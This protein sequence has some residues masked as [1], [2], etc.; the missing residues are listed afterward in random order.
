[1][2]R[3]RGAVRRGV[4][5]L[6]EGARV[7]AWRLLYSWGIDLKLWYKIEYLMSENGALLRR[8]FR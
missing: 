1:M 6:Y 2:R 3:R 4:R 7:N 8:I 5:W